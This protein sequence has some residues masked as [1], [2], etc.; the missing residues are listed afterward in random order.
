MKKD[1]VIFKEGYAIR[2]QFAIHFLTFTICGW[3]DLFTRQVYRDIVLDAFRFAQKQE[4][5]IMHAYV[6]MSNHIHLIVRAY[7]NQKKRLAI[8]F[9]ILKKLLT[10][11]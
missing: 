9:V 3:I 4:Q 2:D 1:T 8:L 11:K 10:T 6:V 7:E 5:L